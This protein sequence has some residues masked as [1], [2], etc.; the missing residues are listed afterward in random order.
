MVKKSLAD[1]PRSAY[2]GGTA[3]AS[4]MTAG[5]AV[6]AAGARFFESFK[7]DVLIMCV[8]TLASKESKLLRQLMI[9]R[10]LCLLDTWG[11]YT[12]KLTAAVTPGT[13][14]GRGQARPVLGRREELGTQSHPEPWSYQKLRAAAKETVSPKS[15]ASE[16]F[17]CFKNSGI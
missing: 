8:P 2:V 6:A 14:P 10:E 1:L 11:S 9:T 15:V 16:T 4:E 13:E 17:L 5:A 7:Q 3:I 12:Y